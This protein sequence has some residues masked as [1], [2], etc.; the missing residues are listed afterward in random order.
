M[1][2]N[3]L[4]QK[5]KVF[6]D[7]ILNISATALPLI[8]L[9]IF[10]YPN[11]AKKIGGIEFG[12]MITIYSIWVMIPN[13]LG[14]VLNNIKLLRFK[15]YEQLGEDG[16]I[17]ILVRQFLVFIVPF[18]FFS[19]W[20]YTKN[21]I[22]QHIIIG[23]IIA[24]LFFLKAYLEVGFW[25]K[26]NYVDVF[27]NSVLLSTG[28][29]IGYFCFEFTG[30]WELIFLFGYLFS[31]LYCFCRTNLLQEVPRKTILYRAIKKDSYSLVISSVIGNLVN[32]ADKLVLYPLMGGMAVS[33]YYTASI[34]GK[35][36]GMLTGPINTVL[37]SYIARWD[38]S[39]S[40]IFSKVLWM[41]LVI[42]IISYILVLL[43][44]KSVLSI[45][46][47]QW[48]DDVMELIPF[49]T[50]TVMLGVLI[51]ILNPFLLKYCNLQWQTVIGSLGA[52]SYFAS[53]F[54]LWFFMGLKGF[55]I[56]TIIGALVRL[57]IMIVVYYK[58]NSRY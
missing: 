24:I 36:T 52:I 26:L 3:N 18:V 20:F 13:A 51:S 27:I 58:S 29:I 15:E 53:A 50:V 46:F 57:V 54:T 48:I 8:M 2:V 6:V 44:A 55:C 14:N 38:K 16:D 10:V 35:I 47:P 12:L 37:L 41:G 33:I 9:Q 56:G 17:A 22:I 30:V 11:V 43:L 25:I 39:K 7:V 40:N 23:T 5:R 31:C 32:Y 4:L 19:I 28:F 34:L 21:F 42:A 49:T 1:T 45:L